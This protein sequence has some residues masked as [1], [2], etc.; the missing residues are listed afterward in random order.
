METSVMNREK[1]I[2][3]TSITGILTNVFLA[4]FKLV[5]GLIANSIAVILDGVNNYTDAL[6][7]VITIIGTKLAGRKPDRKHPLGHGRIEYLSSMIVSA[8]V[9]YAG[10]TSLVESVKKIIHP[11]EADYSALALVILAVAIVVKLVLGRYVKRQGEK[12]HS[13]ALI[14][15]GSDAS[16]DAIL[17]ASVLL[18]AVIF[19]LTRFSLEAYVGVVISLFILKAGVEMIRETL[20]EIL[21][22]RADPEITKAVRDILNSEPEI[23]GAYDLVLNNYGPDAWNGSIHIEVPDTYSADQ[24]DRLLRNIQTTVYKEHQVILTA[25][26]VYSMNTKDEEVIAAQKKVREIVFAHPYV[27][28][29]HGFYLVKEPKTMRFDLVISFDA[30]DRRAAF[31]EAVAD[32]QKAFPDYALQTAMDTD[33]AEE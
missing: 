23:R 29:M 27:R 15:S 11:E 7:S 4:T 19:L 3:R 18:S 32:V 33:F 1:V 21:G 13:G 2:V 16:F 22:Q 12:V 10:L 14:A 9:L 20:S 24:L 30:K 25:I 5:V 31:A 28:Q 26:G 6:S 17:S 8:I